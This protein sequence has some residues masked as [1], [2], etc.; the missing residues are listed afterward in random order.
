MG[1]GPE[2]GC[3]DNINLLQIDKIPASTPS[4]DLLQHILE[5][6]KNGVPLVVTSI[7]YDPC[8]HSRPSF[9]LGVNAPVDYETGIV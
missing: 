7:D 8:W 2:D 3:L 6:E 1:L 4:W 9:S 5:H